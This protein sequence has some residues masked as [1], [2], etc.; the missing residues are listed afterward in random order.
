MKNFILQLAA[1]FLLQSF[2]P[3]KL[4]AA[5]PFIFGADVSWVQQQEDEGRKFSDHGTNADFFAILRAHGFNWIRLRVFNDPQA[6]NGYSA[7][8]YCDLPHTVTTAKRAKA[9]GFRLLL[10]FHYS[11]SWA[12]PG[13]QHR[14]F[15]WRDLDDA[16][17]AKAAGDYTRKTLAAFKAA[18]AL[19]EMVQIGNEISN[20]FLWRDGE[21]NHIQWDVFCDRLNSCIAGAHAVDPNIRIMLHIDCGGNNGK[22][23][24][25][26]DNVLQHGVKFDIIGQSYYPRWHGSLDDLKKNLADLAARYEQP[27]IVAEY[28]VPTVREV[29][30][31]VRAMPNGKGIGSFIWEPTKFPRGDD[32]ALF[33]KSGA[34]KPEIEMYRTLANEFAQ[35]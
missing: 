33:D 2:Q 21:T 30:D 34:A 11:D 17:L 9:A 10:D 5:E 35:P 32:P 14:P 25:F 8:G 26:F 16:A 3:G 7:K 13:H 6:T 12:D 28:S 29:N 31:M 15:A 18:G 4:A 23:R 22:S 20:G 1:I 27:V 24:W 19:P